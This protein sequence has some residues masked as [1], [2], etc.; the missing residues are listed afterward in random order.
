MLAS[1]DRLRTAG[2]AES[3]APLVIA[4]SPTLQAA[5]AI[6]ILAALREHSIVVP[7]RLVGC[8]SSSEVVDLVAAGRAD[9]GIC[10]GAAGT[11]DDLVRSGIGRAEVRLYSP[12]SLDLP[13]RVR[14]DDLSGLPLVLPTLGSRRRQVLDAFFRA[15]G[16]QPEV[17]VETDERHAWLAAVT[18]GIAS[19]IWH[20]VDRS[21]MPLPGVV[22]RGFDP[23]LHRELTALHRPDNPSPALAPLLDVLRQVGALTR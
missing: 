8:S 14:I 11:A 1:I 2:I 4:A 9:L 15:C 12:A 21:P 22:A 20:S 16:V 5:T 18:H 13:E 3:T 10:D 19:C 17:A 23:P 6:P 7:T